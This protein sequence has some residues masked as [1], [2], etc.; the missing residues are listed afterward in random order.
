MEYLLLLQHFREMTSGV[1]DTCML[2]MSSLGEPMVTFGLIAWV[3]WCMDKSSGSVMI[4]STSLACTYGQVLKSLLKVERPWVIDERISPVEAAIPNASGYS[5]PSGHTIRATSSWGALIGRKQSNNYTLGLI[6]VIVSLLVAFSRNYLGVH[7][8]QD[9]VMGLCIA[10]FFIALSC[11]TVKWCE[12]ESKRD[13]IVVALGYILLFV[14]MLRVGC[15]T[16]AGMGMG[17]LLGWC[18]ER[19]LIRFEIVQDVNIKLVRFI[20]GLLVVF[21]L[22]KVLPAS[23]QLFISGKYAGFFANF[24]I[25]LFITVIYPAIFSKIKYYKEVLLLLIALLLCCM[26]LG[27]CY[28]GQQASENTQSSSIDTEIDYAEENTVAVIGHRGYSGEYPENTLS[29]FK[30]AIDMGV[31][32]IELDVQL[33]KDGEVVVYHDNDL[34]RIVGCEG[35]VADY[36]LEELK[37]MDFGSYFSAEYTDER[38][39]TLA[40][41]M[42]LVKTSDCNIYLELKNIGDIDGFVEKVLQTTKEYGM[43]DRCLF[44]SFY[45]PYLEQCKVIDSTLSILYNTTSATESLIQQYPA[46]YYGMYIENINTDIIEA[47]HEA[48][49]QVFVWT[50]N[51]PTQMYLACDMGVD[52]VTSNYVGVA[53]VAVKPAYRQFIERYETS[54]CIPLLCDGK[55]DD[56][57]KTMVPQ[58]LTKVGAQIIISAYS[59]DERQNSLLYVM[60]AEGNLLQRLDLGFKAHVGGVSYDESHDILWICAAE[61]HV[62]GITWSTLITDQVVN[63]VTD[64]DVGLQNHNGS[65]VA[66]FLTYD[67][68]ELYVGSYV[69]GD[70]GAL[71]CYDMAEVT[72]PVLQGEYVIP[73]RIQG[74]TFRMDEK[75][76]TRYMILSQGYQTEDSALLE[77]TY[78]DGT[79]EYLTPARSMILPEGVEQVQMT[80]KGL[81]VLFESGAWPYRETSRV[82]NDQIYL[83]RW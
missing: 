18:V 67:H 68:G 24:F 2:F 42:E 56:I 34:S 65:H 62:Y 14:P 73:Q 16:N 28:R 37:E 1:L 27:Y 66:S 4:C 74:I 30:A 31:D 71:K 40:D 39:P 19:H 38:I 77:F 82:V 45:Y 22:M 60:D 48:G 51:T 57:D 49:S 26:G 25:G 46:E 17:L 64:I 44:A 81:Y 47:I 58:G 33:T 32:Y 61:G 80:A 76:G 35:T 70:Y 7:T 5:M 75:N 83:I 15:M 3:Y 59:K 36:T 23:L 6:G 50:A 43:Q 54:I 12:Q 10:S 9:V 63:V 11:K 79:T 53:N 8:L 13:F 69:D 21:V 78:S 52:G 29:S 55:R 72:H 20:P 41:V